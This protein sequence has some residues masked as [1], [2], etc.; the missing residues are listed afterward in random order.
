[1]WRPEPRPSFTPSVPFARK[2]SEPAGESSSRSAAADAAAPSRERGAA[3]G[4]L[5]AEQPRLGTG[6]GEREY[7]PTSQVAFE[8]ASSRPAEVVRLRYD[9]YRNLV[10]MGVIGGY[11]EPYDPEP[12]PRFAPDPR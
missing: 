9:S 11:R 1:V 7:S 4:E 12:F 10:A 8:R 6:H 5:K 2:D 3:A